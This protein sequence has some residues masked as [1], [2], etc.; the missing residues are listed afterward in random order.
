MDSM[1]VSSGCRSL[2]GNLLASPVIVSLLP[3]GLPDVPPG[4]PN[5]RVGAFFE[6]IRS[7]HLESAHQYP[8]PP[9]APPSPEGTG[10]R[11]AGM[12]R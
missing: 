3:C 4:S 1:G 9:P 12:G 2:C 7:L 11:G 5:I 8:S 10:G 6:A